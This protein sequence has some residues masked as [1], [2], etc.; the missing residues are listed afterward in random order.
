MSGIGF[1]LTDFGAEA[2]SK[3]DE[4]QTNAT[5]QFP[6]LQKE[7][8]LIIKLAERCSTI[9]SER[10]LGDRLSLCTILLASGADAEKSCSRS[11]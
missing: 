3:R 4:C 7:M 5:V 11:S 1:L 6:A 9:G 10:A 8:G 2:A